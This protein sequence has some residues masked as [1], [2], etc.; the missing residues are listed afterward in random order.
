MCTHYEPRSV[1]SVNIHL[2]GPNLPVSAS[3]SLSPL[4]PKVPLANAPQAWVGQGRFGSALGRVESGRD[5]LVRWFY[6]FI[7]FLLFLFFFIF[8]RFSV[9]HYKRC[10]LDKQMLSVSIFSFS[11]SLLFQLCLL[12]GE[13]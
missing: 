10:G 12:A 11:F 5:G 9:F 6:I 3:L 8:L 13:F 2:G 1:L 4:D 7:L